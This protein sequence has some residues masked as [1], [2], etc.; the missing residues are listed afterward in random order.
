[1]SAREAK[2]RTDVIA[3]AKKRGDNDKT[4]DDMNNSSSSVSSVATSSLNESPSSVSEE[5]CVDE[6]FIDSFDCDMADV[7]D[8]DRRSECSDNVDY[9]NGMENEEVELLPEQEE[10]EENEQQ[11]ADEEETEAPR[12]SGR[13]I[14][15]P[16]YLS[17]YR[18][19][20]RFG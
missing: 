2:Q 5:G 20:T 4:T 3:F 9:K 10:G 14:S 18:V 7:L 17:A 1:M 16:S 19:I 13:K 15:L 8:N 11:Q 6:M 12:R